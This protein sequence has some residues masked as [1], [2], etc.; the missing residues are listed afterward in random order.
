M[1]FYGQV[2][3]KYYGSKKQKK[4]RKW[5]SLILPAF[6]LTIAI[7]L[8]FINSRLTPIYI[9]YAEFQTEIIAAH[10]ITQ[11]IKSRSTEIYNVNDIIKNIPN[12]SGAMVTTQF[13]TEIISKTMAEIHSLVESHLDMA[14]SGNMD[15]LPLN[16]N[17]EYDP[18][19]MESHGGVVFF[20]PIG[21]ATNIPLLGNLGPKI[22]IRFHVVGSVHTDVETVVTEFGINNAIVE[23]NVLVK[24]DVQIIVPLATRTT[25]VEQRIPVAFGMIQSPIPQIYNKGDGNAPQIEVPLQ[26][27]GKDN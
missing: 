13:D 11:A 8:Y 2:P 16:E 6:L 26:P 14:E 12:D 7:F 10:V 25:T 1:K 3:R 4:K 18:Q 22:P 23:L 15:M 5:I 9:Q 24:V 20:V 21:Q 17:I 19:A 27:G